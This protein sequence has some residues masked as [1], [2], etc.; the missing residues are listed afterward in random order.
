MNRGL[1]TIR[2]NCG[3]IVVALAVVVCAARPPSSLA[4][5]PP[6]YRLAD[7]KALQHAFVELAEEVRPSV[8]AIRTYK[9]QNP[10]ATGPRLVMRPFSQGSGFVIDANGYIATN[11]HVVAD[12]DVIT[13]ILHNGLK[14]EADLVQADRRSDLAV[15]KI[16][17]EKLKPVRFGDLVNVK[18]NQWAFA[19]GNPFGLANDDGR[20]SV[21]FGV[22]S[23]LG[24]EMTER[25]VGGSDIEYYGNL[26]ETSAAINPG[27]SGG[28]LFNL[29]REVIGVVTAIETSS[30]VNEGHGFAIP[31]DRHTQRIL[32]TLKTGRA[33]RYGFLGVRVRDVDEPESTLVVNARIHRGAQLDEISFPA[34]PAGAAGL[35]ARDI[36]IE[37]D[38]VP[39]E[40]SDHLVRLV[41]FTPVGAEVPVTFLRNGVKRKTTVKLG[42]RQGMLSRADGPQ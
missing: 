23:A 32:D 38:G 11:R 27:S 36:V 17:A 40:N 33:V 37:F 6:R 7:L 22:V 31:I 35:K 10:R 34:G 4:E 29:D 5:I 39:V 12:S 42:D 26:I 13:V 41:G 15:L 21:T 24:R 2:A 3:W 1:L 28:P 30:G 14:Y 19:C 16:D 9:V 8:T 25:L 20:T 18:I